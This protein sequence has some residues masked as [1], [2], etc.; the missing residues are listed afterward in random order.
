MDLI[1]QG[2]GATKRS[3]GIHVRVDDAPDQVSLLWN[4][5]ESLQLYVPETMQGESRLPDLF[6]VPLQY[7]EVGL[8]GLAI[9]SAV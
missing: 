8:T 5:W 4:T 7:I 3:G 2:I 9:V 1:E 6:A